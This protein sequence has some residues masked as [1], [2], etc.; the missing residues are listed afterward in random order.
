MGMPQPKADESDIFRKVE[1]G[2]RINST[3]GSSR[4]AR[5]G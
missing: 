1:T 4:F 2:K 3:T 5:E